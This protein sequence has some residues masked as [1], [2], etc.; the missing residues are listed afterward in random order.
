MKSGVGKLIAKT[1]A[2][3][4]AFI[5]AALL[6]F[7]GVCSL[8]FPSVMVGLTNGLGLERSCAAYSVN[9]YEQTG[10]VADLANAVERS[11]FTAETA[12]DFARVAQLGEQLQA[13][14][15]Y[16]AY[17][18]E[19]GADSASGEFTDYDA[20]ITALIESARAHAAA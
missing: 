11:Y 7:L 16:D 9:L 12:Q 6:L 1:A 3:T 17:C 5:L 14:E 19:Q 2:A 10:D 20:Y 4:L 13:H 15:D 18:A 8:C